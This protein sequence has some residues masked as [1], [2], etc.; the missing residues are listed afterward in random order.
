MPWMRP[1][2]TGGMEMIY[3]LLG[4][5]ASSLALVVA[6]TLLV[7]SVNVIASF[8]RMS[9]FVVGFI[10]MAFGTS[11]PELFV[12]ISSA[13]A[14]NT[15]ITLGTVIGS[16]I[17]NLT[18]VAGLGVL[19]A[20]GIRIESEKTLK[21]STWM[22]GLAVL[23]MVLMIIGSQ[24][25]VIDGIILLA[26]FCAYGYKVIRERS[27]FSKEVKH[28]IKRWQV[29]SHTLLFAASLFLLFFAADLVVNFASLLSVDLALPPILIGLVLVALG[30]SLP[31]LAF[32]ASAIR[33][34]FSQM[35]VGD[36]IGS[37]IANS[38]LVLGVTCIIYPISADM[39][40]FFTSGIFMIIITFLFASFV[41]SGQKLYMKEGIS[42]VM[43]YVFFLIIEYYIKVF[44]G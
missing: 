26:A 35:A 17:A 21:D 37:V 5:L 20:G 30:T 25:G 19:L 10:I 34:G 38:T 44:S 41:E 13:V 2:D 32:N 24:L 33:R 27:Q 22:V 6:G 29:I 4:L 15:A 8:L 9:E 7:K 3:N 12:G 28:P 23:P 43:M 11:V 16:N 18:I 36:L 40:L 1:E 42:M 39:L 31:E 14:K